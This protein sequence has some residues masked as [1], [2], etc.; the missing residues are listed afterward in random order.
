M[1]RL[2]PTCSVIVAESD[3]SIVF[4]GIVLGGLT[5]YVMSQTVQLAL[6]DAQC[7]VPFLVVNPAGS[8]TTKMA[9][10]TTSLNVCVLET[11]RVPST[12]PVNEIVTDRSFPRSG[13]F[14]RSSVL[15]QSVEVS[16]TL[17]V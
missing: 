10:P 9:P 15:D 11:W 4:D 6:L 3:E 16:G 14:F 2:A 8:G 5:G 7:V 17:P 12:S 13:N 1:M